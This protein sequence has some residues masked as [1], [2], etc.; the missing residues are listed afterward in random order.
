PGCEQIEREGHAGK[1]IRRQPLRVDHRADFAIGSFAPGDVGDFGR[2]EI[3]AS[4]ACRLRDPAAEFAT[5][6][7][8]VNIAADREVAVL[9]PER[10]EQAGG[11]AEPRIERLMDAVL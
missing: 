3:T 7:V 6:A 8:L 5:F 1:K 2:E 4:P 11:R 10:L 9:A